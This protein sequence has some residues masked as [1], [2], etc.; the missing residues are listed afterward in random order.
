MFTLLVVFASVNGKDS[1]HLEQNFRQI[2]KLATDLS[3]NNIHGKINFKQLK[4]AYL[5]VI[6]YLEERH[7]TT[8]SNEEKTFIERES[9]K[10]FFAFVLFCFTS[11]HQA[12]AVK[13]L[14]WIH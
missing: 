6:H 7:R 13:T 2:G 14:H 3:Y 10:T 4:V 9:F 11:D 12:F 5:S 1:V 8:G